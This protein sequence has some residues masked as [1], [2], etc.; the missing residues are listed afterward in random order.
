MTC[1]IIHVKIG[2]VVS[3]VFQFLDIILYTVYRFKLLT[4]Y[5]R[6][7]GFNVHNRDSAE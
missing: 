2:V 1:Q 7:P 3:T 6:T 5:L 4:V